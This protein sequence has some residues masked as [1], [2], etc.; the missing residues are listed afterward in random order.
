VLQT[1]SV[2]TKIL[3]VSVSEILCIFLLNKS[4]VIC[5]TPVET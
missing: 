2:L 3:N 4:E 1:R 5:K